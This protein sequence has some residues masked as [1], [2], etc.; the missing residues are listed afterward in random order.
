[1]TIQGVFSTFKQKTYFKSTVQKI[2]LGLTPP[3]IPS[4]GVSPMIPITVSSK[5]VRLRGGGPPPVRFNSFLWFAAF[6]CFQHVCCPLFSYFF[7]ASHMSSGIAG[8]HLGTHGFPNTL[9]CHCLLSWM[10][11]WKKIFN[12]FQQGLESYLWV[13]LSLM[14]WLTLSIVV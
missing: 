1:M 8:I 9:F 13:F 11:G 6:F 5:G 10:K 7:H 2:S 12:L 3:G 4:I 14:P